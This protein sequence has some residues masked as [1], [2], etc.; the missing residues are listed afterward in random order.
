MRNP[1]ADARVA[2]TRDP[3][4]EQRGETHDVC[5][6]G[7]GPRFSDSVAAAVVGPASRRGPGRRSK[8][9]REDRRGPPA[10]Q[11]PSRRGG[12]LPKRH[13]LGHRATSPATGGGAGPAENKSKGGIRPVP[14]RKTGRADAGPARRGD[15]GHAGPDARPTP[16]RVF[17]SSSWLERKG[18]CGRVHRRVDERSS[19]HRPR[20]MSCP[21]IP[22]KRRAPRG[23][24]SPFRLR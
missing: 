14:A 8:R 13:R 21:G 18:A 9:E 20:T 11:G 3:A 17:R 6:G 12:R 4:R 22:L 16:G 2:S 19:S 5:S 10:C 7:R 23:S 1:G 24:R 15:R